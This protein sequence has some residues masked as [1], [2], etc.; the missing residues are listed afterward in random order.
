MDTP[1]L[2]SSQVGGGSSFNKSGASVRQPNADIGE[3]MMATPTIKI[4]KRFENRTVVLSFSNYERL[5]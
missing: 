3:P 4:N 2:P 1:E 5:L